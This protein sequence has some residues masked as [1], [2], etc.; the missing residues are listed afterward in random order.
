MKFSTLLAAVLAATYLMSAAVFAVPDASSS[1]DSR[2]IKRERDNAEMKPKH[3]DKDKLKEK[4]EE[5][6]RDPIKVLESR[7]E[8]I[9][10]M[11]K[12]GKITKEKAD[13]IT[14][15]INAKISEIQEFNKL[16]VKQKKEKLMSDFKAH[17][18]KKIE[19]GKI[20][21]EKADA[22]LREFAEKIEKWDGNGYP[23]FRMRSFKE[24][25]R[26]KKE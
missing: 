10:T 3:L 5:F 25:C 6:H 15:R 1:L 7:K 19:K 21:R 2:S 22:M 23:S 12:E 8:K 24:K 11:L 9:Q 20:T 26:S 16:T 18:E 14:A 13:A 4:H 17:A